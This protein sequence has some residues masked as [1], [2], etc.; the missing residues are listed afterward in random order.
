MSSSLQIIQNVGSDGNWQITA[1]VLPG[2]TLPL[3]IFI[4]EN[5]GTTTLGQYVGVCNLDEYQRLQTFTGTAI[6]VFGNRFVKYTQG[7]IPDCP[8]NDLVQAT[9]CIEN[10]VKALSLAF[11]NASSSTL[12]INIP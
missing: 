8:T 1:N 12:I 2:G 11:T 6:A 5:T 9:T 10:E 4:Y 3:D 7:V